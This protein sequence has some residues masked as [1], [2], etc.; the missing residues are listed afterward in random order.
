MTDGEAQ[1]CVF[2]CPGDFLFEEL[3]NIVLLFLFVFLVAGGCRMYIAPTAPTFRF[4]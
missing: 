3:R 4:T 2:A 1:F